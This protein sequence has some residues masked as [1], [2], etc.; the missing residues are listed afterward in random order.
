[1][2]ELYKTAAAASKENDGGALLEI[3][4][5]LGIDIDVDPQ[6]EGEWLKEKINKLNAEIANIEHDVRWVWYHS[7]EDKR[8][9]LEDAIEKQTIFTKK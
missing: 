7:D 3:A 4:Y 1:M 6:K 2:T 9:S 5:E 8:A